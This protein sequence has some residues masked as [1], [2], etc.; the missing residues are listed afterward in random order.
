MQRYDVYESALQVVP[1]ATQDETPSYGSARIAQGLCHMHALTQ[2]LCRQSIYCHWQAMDPELTNLHS[3]FEQQ[4]QSLRIASD[5]IAARIEALGYALPNT[6]SEAVWGTDPD[7]AR[8]LS[9]MISRIVRNHQACAR[10]ARK[11]LNIADLS[12]DTLSAHL[13]SQRLTVHE[14]AAMLLMTIAPTAITRSAG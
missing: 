1:P 12:G 3:L 13:S 2:S 14:K 7:D 6:T 8:P 5:I 9:E 4:Y 10:E 11:V